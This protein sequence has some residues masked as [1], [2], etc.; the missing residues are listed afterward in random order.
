MKRLSIFI[1]VKKRCLD[2]TEKTLYYLRPLSCLLLIIGQ[3]GFGI[4]RQNNI[5]VCPDWNTQRDMLKKKGY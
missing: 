1:E 5:P 4:N 2:D 3:N